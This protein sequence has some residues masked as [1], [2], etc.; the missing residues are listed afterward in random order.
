[1]LLELHQL[2]YGGVLVSGLYEKVGDLPPELD[3]SRILG[4]EA[5]KDL[6]G[7]VRLAAAPQA[8]GAPELGS[9]VVL[10]IGFKSL[11][12]GRDAIRREE[13]RAH[14]FV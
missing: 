1:M 4:G 13:D 6:E 12:P 7:L 8:L 3:V 2:G 14:S 10:Q 11:G 5:T 9:F